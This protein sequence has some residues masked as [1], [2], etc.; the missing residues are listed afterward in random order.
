MTKLIVSFLKITNRANVF[1]FCNG[2][3]ATLANTSTKVG[4]PRRG[5]VR[6]RAPTAALPRPTRERS[7]LLGFHTL[8]ELI[9]CHSNK[10]R[11]TFKLPRDARTRSPIYPSRLRYRWPSPN[12]MRRRPRFNSK[13]KQPL[14]CSK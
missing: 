2:N 6:D 7:Q 12:R 10:T 14:R 11:F 5:L 4:H 8:P 3:G 1:I 13:I 9:A